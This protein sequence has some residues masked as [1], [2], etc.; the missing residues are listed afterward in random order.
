MAFKNNWRETALAR[1]NEIATGSI[2]DI[3]NQSNA[4]IAETFIGADAVVLIDTSSSMTANDSR[5]GQSR[6]DV[7]V[8]ELQDLQ[9]TM[10]GKIAVLSFADNC[11]FCPNGIPHRP[12]GMTNLL[13]TLEMAKIADVANMRFILI[14][15]G[16][17][18]DR[19]QCVSM[20]STFSNRIDCIYVGPEHDQV[21]QDCL[22]EIATASGGV[23]STSICVNELSSDIQL[24]LI[25]SA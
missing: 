23:S 20:A 13:S 5:D 11:Y 6:Y 9:K 14:S 3:A 7:A 18:N 22:N 24:L 19:R 16:Q 17:P 21:A 10:S 15:D 8:N 12:N 4:S 2:E 25:A 1:R